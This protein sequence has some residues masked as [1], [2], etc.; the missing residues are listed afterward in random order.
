MTGSFIE[1]IKSAIWRYSMINRGDVVIVAVSGGADS[2]ALLHV[3]RN[4]KSE[5]GI[6]L[7]AAHINHGIRGED[8][9]QDA[10]FVQ[11]LAAR[12]GLASVVEKVDVPAFSRKIRAGLEET[13]RKVRYEFLER[14]AKDSGAVRIAVAHTADD[15]A[16]TVLLNIIRGAGLDG[17]SGMPAVRGKI[18]R[19]L[20]EAFRTDVEAYLRENKIDWRTDITNLSPEYTRNR[21]RLQ[22]IPMLETEFNPRVKDSLISLSRLARDEAEAAE[23]ATELEFR[24]A[25]KEAGQ[26]SVVLDAALLKNLPKALLRR[27]VRKAIEMV[28]GDL[29]DI[30]YMQVERIAENVVENEDFS[31]TLPSGVIYARL[32]EGE[33][34]I[35]RIVEPPKIEVERELKLEGTTDVPELGVSF[36]TRFIP[37]NIRPEKASQAV[38]DPKS[39]T[40]KLTVRTWKPGDRIAPLGMAGHKKLQDLF[41]DAKVPR[42]ER[43]R[44][45]IVADEAKIVWAVGL[46]ISNLARVTKDTELALWIECFSLG[47]R[48]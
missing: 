15:Q 12:F 26:E 45:P 17:L 43:G 39:I 22:L 44:I 35:F 10:L 20:I 11:E 48:E 3:L 14:V 16:E 36:E 28:K 34:R 19:P 5:L 18:I 2:V 8:A 40:G 32:T 23:S 7:I 29:R 42:R 41:T 38:L 24:A 6:E 21:V 31:L 33:L 25:A 37:A 1:N 9:D 47:N 27:C 4:M 46:T 30:E 13:A